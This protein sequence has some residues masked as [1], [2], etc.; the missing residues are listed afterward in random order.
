MCFVFY[1]WI[2]SQ[3]TAYVYK[4]PKLGHFRSADQSNK[5]APIVRLNSQHMFYLFNKM[6]GV[7]SGASGFKGVVI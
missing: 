5:A 2:P 4:M 6:E 3:I 7:N 1:S